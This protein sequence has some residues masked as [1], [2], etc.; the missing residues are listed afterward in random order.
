MFVF[1]EEEFSS[2]VKRKQESREIKASLQSQISTRRH[3]YLIINND[4]NRLLRF[5]GFVSQ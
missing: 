2:K 5:N 3:Y 4:L 1:V